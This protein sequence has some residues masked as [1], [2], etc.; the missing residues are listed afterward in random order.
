SWISDKSIIQYS[1]NYRNNM[2]V[3]IF[4]LTEHV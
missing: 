1:D 2:S 3:Q 4:L